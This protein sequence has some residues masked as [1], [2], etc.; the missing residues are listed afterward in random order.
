MFISDFQLRRVVFPAV[1]GL[2]LAGLTGHSQ[3]EPGEVVF[4]EIPDRFTQLQDQLGFFWQADQ[5]GSLT[6]GDT[7]Y[8]ASGMRLGVNGADFTPTK[9][10]LRDGSKTGGVVDLILN[11]ERKDFPIQRSLWFD[12]DRGGVRLIDTV[13]NNSGQ[14]ASIPVEFRTTYPFA[15][16]NLYGS[17]G[18]LLEKDPNPQLGERDTGVVVKFSQSEGRQDTLILT[19]GEKDGLRPSISGSANQRELVL[20]Y[21]L[22]VEAG[23]S[24]SLVHWILQRNLGSPD[25]TEVEWS[26]F[27]QRRRLINSRVPGD[28]AASVANFDTSAFP[29]SGS[30]PARLQSLTNLNDLTDRIGLHRREED[31]LWVSAANQLAGKINPAAKVT[32]KNSYAGDGVFP[33]GKVAAIAGGSGIGRTPKLYLRDGRVFSGP[34]T[35]EG[36]TLE[37]GT[38]SN[39]DDLKPEDFNLL[40]CALAPEDGVPPPGTVGFVQVRSDSVLAVKESEEVKI[41]TINPWGEEILALSDIKELGY[42]SRPTPRF[43]LVRSDRSRIS[44]FLPVETIN[45]QLAEG[46]PVDLST[47]MIEHYRNVDLVEITINP[48]EDFWLDASEVPTAL[49][50]ANGFLLKGNNL[51]SGALEEKVITVIDEQST[52]DISTG[53]IESIQRVLDS[54]GASVPIFEIEIKNGDVLK[55]RLQGSDLAIQYRGEVWNVP[56]PHLLAFWSK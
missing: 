26:T 10:I 6:S 52:V 41:T 17:R 37:I 48:I 21:E 12:Q 23:K 55:G 43:R 3:E 42:I 27:Y 8:L 29:Q 4:T 40:L 36:L 14:A 16:Q 5:Y 44:V 34:I 45:L 32:V 7:Q 28:I 2:F 31:I 54:G 30:V 51:V 39:V 1:A 24:V 11:E 13:T 56:V 18:E 50:P 22:S 19:S 15:W 53:E 49:R 25:D 47:S 33:I 46:E 20:R 9:A 35:A 38:D